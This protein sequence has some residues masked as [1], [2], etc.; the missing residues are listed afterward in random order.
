ML[1]CNP[2]IE[3]QTQSKVRGRTVR[4]LSRPFFLS[5]WRA[6]ICACRAGAQRLA[7]GAQRSAW[8]T[9]TWGRFWEIVP[10]GQG[11]TILSLRQTSRGRALSIVRLCIHT[12]LRASG[13][14]SHYSPRYPVR[15]YLRSVLCCNLSAGC[16]ACLSFPTV[17]C[18]NLPTSWPWLGW[19]GAPRADGGRGFR[20]Q[21]FWTRGHLRV[22]RFSHFMYFY[23]PLNR[24]PLFLCPATYP[25]CPRYY[26]VNTRRRKS[27]THSLRNQVKSSTSLSPRPI[28]SLCAGSR[29]PLITMYS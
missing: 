1:L 19:R 28:W 2:G 9:R 16:R 5:M 26:L 17:P 27:T 12:G 21:L 24:P 22:M 18:F 29:A 10:A 20:S 4:P 23:P 11:L 3:P 6:E 25:S 8:V 7:A 13:A 15:E 14:S